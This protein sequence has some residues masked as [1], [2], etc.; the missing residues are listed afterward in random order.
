MAGKKRTSSAQLPIPTG[1]TAQ[2][3]SLMYGRIKKSLDKAARGESVLA[4]GG[5]SARRNHALG[6]EPP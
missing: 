6:H 3:L 2:A 1:R 5:F 4:N